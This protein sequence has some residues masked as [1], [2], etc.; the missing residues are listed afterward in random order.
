MGLRAGA[1]PERLAVL[2]MSS[3][4]A[5]Q[6]SLA[7]SRTG[8]ESGMQPSAS[9]RTPAE[10]LA[11]LKTSSFKNRVLSARPSASTR[12]PAEPDLQAPPAPKPQSVPPSRV[13]PLP[14]H[15]RATAAL[16]TA[17]QSRACTHEPVGPARPAQR[18]A[19]HPSQ[20]QPF[21]PLRAP[22]AAAFRL[23]Q[24]RA[25][26][27]PR[28]RADTATQGPAATRT[29]DTATRTPRLGQRRRRASDPAESNQRT[30]RP[31]G[32][33]GSAEAGGVSTRSGAS[34]QM[35]P[36]PAGAS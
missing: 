8:P 21:G 18:S 16:E 25:T 36:A 26:P 13:R 27:T 4:R 14:S 6:A 1:V 23:P 17:G 19:A 9:T 10:P 34:P 33:R 11:V 29:A 35:R 2:K 5:I 22:G 24:G 20:P 28:L 12:T 31:P 30:R 32:A 15:A 3:H 7:V